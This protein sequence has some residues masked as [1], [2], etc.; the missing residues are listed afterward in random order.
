MMRS[1]S[2][3]RHRFPPEVIQPRAGRIWNLDAMVVRIG[4]KRMFMRRTVDNEGEVLDLLVRKRRNKAAAPK[5]L[6]KMLKKYGV[7]LKS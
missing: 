5:L 4:G 2:F 1:I 6:R 3:K 7:M